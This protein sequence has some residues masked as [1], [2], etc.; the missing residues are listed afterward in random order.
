MRRYRVRVLERDGRAHVVLRRPLAGYGA[1]ISIAVID[2]SAADARRT[3]GR[4]ASAGYCASASGQRPGTGSPMTAREL[5][6][7]SECPAP[8]YDDGQITLYHGRCEDILPTLDPVDLIFTS[9]PYNLGVSTGGGFAAPGRE[10]GLWSGGPLADGYGEH[11]DAMPWDEYVAWQQDVLR[12]CWAQLT[13]AGAI[14]YNHKPRVQAGALITPLVLNPG[15]P[16]RQIVVW[17]RG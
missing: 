5:S 11:D 17:D 15:L 13:E 3:V 10:T 12:L 14:F 1:H 4:C 7:I 6:S 9:P 16:V 8:Y 2:L